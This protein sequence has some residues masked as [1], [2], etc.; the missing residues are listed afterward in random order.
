MTIWWIGIDLLY[1]HLATAF[2]QYSGTISNYCECVGVNAWACSNRIKW[3]FRWHTE[4][5]NI[6]THLIG[7]LIFIGLTL[8]Y[9]LLPNMRFTGNYFTLRSFMITFLRRYQCHT[10][11]EFCKTHRDRFSIAFLTKRGFILDGWISKEFMM[12]FYFGNA[13]F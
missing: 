7:G 5:G 12:L 2:L 4:T 1:P 3:S 13:I 8:Y 6:W 9:L 11:V 10:F